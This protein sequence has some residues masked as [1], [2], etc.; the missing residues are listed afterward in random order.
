M[1]SQRLICWTVA[2]AVLLVASATAPAAVTVTPLGGSGFALQEFY[3]LNT[4]A[5][6]GYTQ[7]TGYTLGYT[8]VAAV[9]AGATPGAT[10]Q[11]NADW[12]IP[13]IND[14][15]YRGVGRTGTWL[16]RTDTANENTWVAFAS[17][18]TIDTMA[19][20]HSFDNGVAD[21]T[22]TVAYTSDATVND[23]STWTNFG[24]ITIDAGEERRDVYTFNPISGVTGL[25]LEINGTMGAG[26]G[27]DRWVDLAEVEAYDTS[28]PP[29]FPPP[30]VVDFD[31]SD[32]ALGDGDPVTTWD[33]QAASGSPTYRAGQT[34][35]GRPA[36]EMNGSDHFGTRVLP[37]SAAGDFIIAAVLKPTD[38]GGY[39]NLIDDDPQTRPMLWIDPS[40]N[41]EFNFSGGT[42]AK[43]AGTGIDGWDILIADSR[44][45][46]LYV[47]SPTPNATG[48]NPVTYSGAKY[49]DF[50]NRDN[51]ATFQGMV[52][53]F[54]V[55]NDA[56]GFG[57]DFEGLYR[58]LFQKWMVP[59]PTSFAVWGLGLVGLLLVVRRRR[60]A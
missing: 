13:K 21:G 51:G 53:E 3:N 58:Q 31:A 32:L 35:G 46:Q 57:G 26:G 38:T 16:G 5:D 43:A 22:Y 9:V 60:A 55:Y 11:V 18:Q 40:F 54:R 34:P 50:F 6:P 49:F 19:L 1:T 25:R 2:I 12:G 4:P 59:E 10:G 45:N 36:V 7:Y 37:P 14:G 28:G 52:A 8:N 33:G 30:R 47:N 44:L 23:S 27:A 20:S 17:A 24:Q 48:R 56:A 42:G 39:H 15:D 41:Y 29:V